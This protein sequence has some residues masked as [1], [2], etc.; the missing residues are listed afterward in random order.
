VLS[1]RELLGTVLLAVGG[2]PAPLARPRP[3]GAA[4]PGGV[5]E[6]R[7]RSD[8]RGTVVWFDPVGVRVEPGQVVRWTMAS[9]GNPHTATAYHPRNARHS[10]RI[11]AGAEPWDSG[12]LVE[13]GDRFE[14]RLS[15]EGVYDYFCLPHEAAGMVG[16]IVVGRPAG[17]GTQPFDYFVGRPGS[18]GWQRVPP[19]ARAAFPSVES[20]LA[21]GAVSR[22]AAGMHGD[23]RG[24]A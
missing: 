15:V 16:R 1:R 17:P 22:R 5:V 21:L 18:E 23:D 6:I 13:P 11:P 7:M 12:F 8:A 19:A 10:L 3:A 2:V 14:V 4:A 20:I 24:A 9:P